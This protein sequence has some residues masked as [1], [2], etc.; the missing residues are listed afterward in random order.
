MMRF[1]WILLLCVLLCFTCSKNDDDDDDDNDNDDNGDDDTGDDDVGDD[2]D[3]DDNNDNDT[4]DDDTG[5]DDVVDDGPVEPE[6]LELVDGGALGGIG[7][8]FSVGPDGTKYIATTNAR[9]VLLYT[10]A[11]GK[12][13]ERIRLIWG[14]SKPL[15]EVRPDGVIYV[16]YGELEGPL[17]LL[18]TEQGEWQR[19]MIYQCDGVINGWDMTFDSEDNLWV[20]F[21]VDESQV[22]VGK[23]T[24]GQWQTGQV[25]GATHFTWQTSLA[26]DPQGHA[27]LA[28]DDEYDP[29]YLTNKS[30]TWQSFSLPGDMDNGHYHV[31][32]DEQGTPHVIACVGYGYI[33]W[34]V[35]W[36]DLRRVNNQWEWSMI[37]FE[38][39]TFP[40]SLDVTT[41]ADGTLTLMIHEGT[42]HLRGYRYLDGAWQQT[43]LS[44]YSVEAHF[45]GL[46]YDSEG[47]L[48]MAYY[49]GNVG[50]VTY[51]RV[52]QPNW[53][54]EPL[55]G[56]PYVDKSTADPVMMSDADGNEQILYR[57]AGP[58]HTVA[59]DILQLARRD[60]RGWDMQ[61]VVN[62]PG[63]GWQHAAA[64]TATGSPLVIFFLDDGTNYDFWYARKQGDQWQTGKICDGKYPLHVDLFIDDAGHAHACGYFGDYSTGRLLYITDAGGAWTTEIVDTGF[65]YPG[66]CSI[67]V[68]QQDRPVIGFAK[69][70]VYDESDLYIRRKQG[71]QWETIYEETELET[72]SPFLDIDADGYLHAAFTLPED[73][74]ASTVRYVTNRSGQWV[75]QDAVDEGVRIAY[76]DFALD[77]A[78]Q[79]H[80]LYQAFNR[81]DLR[82]AA[83]DSQQWQFETLDSLGSVGWSPSLNFTGDNHLITAYLGECSLWR[84]SQKPAY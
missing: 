50:K 41:A 40:E 15:I 70:V 9:D 52:D 66:Y 71:E 69:S 4:G 6:N 28:I 57:I 18:H 14:G 53:Q 22:I 2:D 11:P 84:L 37:R 78:D 39:L 82:H 60:N 1:A 25:F 46:D 17:Y 73:G 67:V 51:A 10:Q 12:G 76:M 31:A 54:V 42:D 19:E 55:E 81:R 63:L 7:L 24:D 43:M 47:R 64:M 5:D 26:V 13:W 61:T 65:V 80:L 56:S 21:Y 75:S 16:V 74:E 58:Y 3:D 77:A 23:R 59:H 38:S 8:S 20:S 33:Y 27:H 29:Q 83:L 72:G 62:E 35:A 79:P 49:D 34:T 36:W 30:G 32:I 48:H 44:D 68:D 45:L